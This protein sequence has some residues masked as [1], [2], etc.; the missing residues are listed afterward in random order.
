[1]N[2]D[3]DSG[4]LT[5][6]AG[7]LA[8]SGS[9]IVPALLDVLGDEAQAL[10]KLWRANA[11]ASAGPHGKWY[12]SSIDYEVRLGEGSLYAE[13]GPNIAKRQGGMGRGFEYGSIRQPPHLDGAR[14]YAVRAQPYTRAVEGRV[15]S[16]LEQYG[17]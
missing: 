2:L 1:M 10:Q 9:G 13:I 14:T 3:L 8:A 4:D 6:L 12:P 17:L 15:G 16:L 7:D 5:Q 11:R